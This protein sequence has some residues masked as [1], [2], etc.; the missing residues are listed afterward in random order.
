MILIRLFI[1]LLTHV[2]TIK[3]RLNNTDVRRFETSFLTT[4]NL[5]VSG[6]TVS[7]FD[8]R[9]SVPNLISVEYKRTGVFRNDNCLNL[10]LNQKCNVCEHTDWGIA[11]E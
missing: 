3:A 5:Q 11:A 4:C 7:G 2:F 8:T 9:G 6:S 1:E 10:L